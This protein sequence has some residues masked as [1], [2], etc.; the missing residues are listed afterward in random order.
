MEETDQHKP[1]LLESQGDAVFG[2]ASPEEE[3]KHRSRTF[4]PLFLE[5]Q[6]D[7]FVDEE[8]SKQRGAPIRKVWFGLMALVLAIAAIL[9]FCKNGSQPVSDIDLWANVV[10]PG[11]DI[12]NLNETAPQYRALEWLVYY[13]TQGLTINGDAT[14]L[15]ERFSLV[16]FFFSAG[17]DYSSPLLKSSPCDWFT[18]N[19]D[20]DGRVTRLQSWG[21]K[22]HGTLPTEI[23][24]LQQLTDIVLM[25]QQFSGPIPSEIG[26][27]PQLTK[28]DFL[29][30]NFSGPIPSEIGN[31][32]QLRSLVLN[33]NKLSG[34]I[35][36]EIGNLQ[37]LRSLGLNGNK[38]AGT[39]PSEIGNL[40]Q[41][42]VLHLN[43]NIGLNGTVP[44]EVGQ[45]ESLTEAD[46]A[47]TSLTGGLDDDGSVFCKNTHHHY[48]LILRADCGGLNPKIICECCDQCCS[49]DG[50]DTV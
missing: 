46:F 41:L 22:M 34:P 36:S 28:L 29:R 12:S 14:K 50:C 26:N 15:L 45:L 6:E 2:R 49:I 17:A 4:K 11:V 20:E 18:Y 27:L 48:H 38:F 25:D 39:I 7:V 43:G 10:L 35:P 3:D 33:D 40:Q 5:S 19:C 8:E 30:N 13:D 42:K 16:T 21:M 9:A 44:V 24:N 31:L 1:L 32:Q 37:Q 47:F 23:G